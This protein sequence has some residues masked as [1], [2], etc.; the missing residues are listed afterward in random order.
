[1]PAQQFEICD[2]GSDASTGTIDESAPTLT[3]SAANNNRADG[4]IARILSLVGTFQS[5]L[6]TRHLIDSRESTS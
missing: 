5:T 4:F 3:A 2:F 1:L 6:S